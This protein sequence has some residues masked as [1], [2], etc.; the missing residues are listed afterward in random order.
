[1]GLTTWTMLTLMTQVTGVSAPYKD[2]LKS[3]DHHTLME[4]PDNHRLSLKVEDNQPN[5][6]LHID[7]NTQVVMDFEL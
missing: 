2:Q 6:K 4:Q 5:I 1:M 3:T 7:T